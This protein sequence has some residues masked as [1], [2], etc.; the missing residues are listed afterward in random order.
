MPTVRCHMR[1]LALA[2]QGPTAGDATKVSPISNLRQPTP[3]NSL[4]TV[5]SSTRPTNPDVSDGCVDACAVL[6]E[7]QSPYD[8]TTASNTAPAIGA[9]PMS[10]TTPAA[11]RKHQT[12]S[13]GADSDSA[14]PAPTT[15]RR[16]I[17]SDPLSDQATAALI[18]RVLC[19]QQQHGDKTRDAQTPIEELLPP[20]TSRNDVD[21]ELY[22]FLA[23]ILR[24]FVQSWY[25]RITTDETFVAEIV[26]T[27][28]HCTRA[29]EQRFRKVDMESL[30]FDEVPD[31]LQKHMTG[32]DA[33]VYWYLW[34]RITWLT[35]HTHKTTA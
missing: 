33:V 13:S 16:P 3:T 26:H 12:A 1:H 24:E 29:L 31:L 17:S 35:G 18:R 9:A 2:L 30:L 14:A 20:L 21:L 11:R 7:A 6:E 10:T 5:T 15:S 27:I 19:P 8:M 28:A 34:T 25:S 23:I 32:E 22:A 4:T